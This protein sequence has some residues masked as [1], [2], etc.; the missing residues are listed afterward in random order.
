MFL[1]LE[2]PHPKPALTALPHVG[3]SGNIFTQHHA[4]G[5]LFIETT[6]EREATFDIPLPANTKGIKVRRWWTSSPC[7]TKLEYHI[8]HRASQPLLHA[9]LI[10][11]FVPRPGEYMAQ[12]VICLDGADHKIIVLEATANI[13]TSLE[14][15]RNPPAAIEISAGEQRQIE[16]SA[17]VRYPPRE[18]LQLIRFACPE[19]NVEVV[20]KN[21]EILGTRDHWV[22]ARINLNIKIR[23]SS[24]AEP[25]KTLIIGFLGKRELGR[26]PFQWETRSLLI[27]EPR[28]LVFES[29]N[30]NHSWRIFSRNASPFRILKIRP[31]P[32][33]RVSALP[34][35]EVV[36]CVL[37]VQFV[38]EAMN[39]N[40]SP[41]STIQLETTLGTAKVVAYSTILKKG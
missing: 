10:V 34:T 6:T 18:S 23:G 30:Q 27:S 40:F 15:V 17:I 32:G 28:V 8:D 5:S 9:K 38:N 20:I 16:L 2:P 39:S 41:N 22:E 13:V 24:Q 19:P 37:R 29:Q 3:E 12:G 21:R 4:F 36:E 25:V 7:C 11:K 1:R 26:L 14:W 35:T 31:A 33:Y